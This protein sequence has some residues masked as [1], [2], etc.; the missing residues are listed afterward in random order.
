MKYFEALGEAVGKRWRE[1]NRDERAFPDIAAGAI[2][3]LPPGDRVSFRDVLFWASGLDHLPEQADPGRTFGD[4]PLTVFHGEGFYIDLLF[5]L[6]GTTCIHQHSF[7]GAFHVLAGSSLHSRYRFAI[8]ERV[9]SRFLFGK[10]SLDETEILEPGATRPI[11]AGDELIHSLFHLERPSVTLAIRTRFDPDRQPQYRYRRPGIASFVRDQDTSAEQ[12]QLDCLGVLRSIDHADYLDCARS[13]MERSD[14]G[15]VDRMLV[16]HLA[17]DGYD[18]TFEKLLDAARPLFRDRFEM[19]RESYDAAAREAAIISRR[20]R[21]TDP[22]HRFF[23][24]L[25]LNLPD[26]AT[27]FDLVRRR[28]SRD[29]AELIADWVEAMAKKPDDGG[30]SAIDIDLDETALLVFRFL[31][32]GTSIDELKKRLDEKFSGVDE[33]EADL[34]ELRD[35]FRESIFRPLFVE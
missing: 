17:A 25:I 2:R 1:R 29:P 4:P 22:D 19:M 3:E 34:I 14:L 35:A 13:Y 27:I 30:A 32:R 21:I 20:Q 15:R 8:E 6:D 26:R 9:N 28:Y 11:P 31:L 33:S 16:S 23:L 12:R 5:W 24:A 18:E 7:S 10:L